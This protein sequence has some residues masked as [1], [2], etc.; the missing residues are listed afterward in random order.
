MG[1]TGSPRNLTMGWTGSRSN[2]GPSRSFPL[3]CSP[4]SCN[5][6][7]ALMN[8]SSSSRILSGVPEML[9]H[10]LYGFQ[11]RGALRILHMTFQ[12]D[13]QIDSSTN[14]PLLCPPNIWNLWK[15]L[16]HF[17]YAGQKIFKL[18][19][20]FY[21]K[22]E[23]L[24]CFLIILRNTMPKSITASKPHIFTSSI[25]QFNGCLITL[26]CLLMILLC[27]KSKLKTQSKSEQCLWVIMFCCTTEQFKCLFKV[28][29]VIDPIANK[30]SHFQLQF[31]PIC[32]SYV[33]LHNVQVLLGECIQ[34]YEVYGKI[35]LQ[36][37]LETLL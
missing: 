30:L 28:S 26:D 10:V 8:P 25:F 1:R 36:T 24:I 14:L 27:T 6:H 34:Y 5:L 37:I 9:Q 22:L 23:H 15:A 32:T 7:T 12:F 4:M 35:L 11:E 17:W 18:V 3:E 13:F 20:F 21:S 19:L 16:Q 33:L 31:D 29:L 2:T